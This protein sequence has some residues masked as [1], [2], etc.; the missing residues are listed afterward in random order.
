MTSKGGRPS[1]PKTRCSGK[2]TESQFRSFVKGNLRR[3]C[4]KWAPIQEVKK[5]ARIG[6]NQY[7]CACCEQIVGSSVVADGKRVNNI[8]VDHVVPVV[9]PAVGWTTWDDCIEAMFCE[10]DN[11]QLLCLACHTEKSAEERAI[12]VERRKREKETQ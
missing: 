12:A 4:G 10:K 2:W 8:F 7:K 9:D 5:E 11:L 1:A 6:R 3:V